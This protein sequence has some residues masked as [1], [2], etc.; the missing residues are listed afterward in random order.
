VALPAQP[1][2]LLLTSLGKGKTVVLTVLVDGKETPRE[3]V[4]EEG[5]PD[6]ESA[7]R[8]KDETTGLTVRDLTYEARRALKLPPDAPGVVV[9]RVEEGSPAAGAKVQPYDVLQRVEGRSVNGAA[10][11]VA[12]LEAAHRA[13]AATV[14][15]QVLR[16][17]RTRY[18]DLG[19]EADGDKAPG[20]R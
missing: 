16:L 19:F 8:K 15:V 20:A 3:L 18:V 5:P 14:K 10:E 12:A 7:E 6:Y 2:N 4:L 13:G 17:N 9:S 1:P 11:F